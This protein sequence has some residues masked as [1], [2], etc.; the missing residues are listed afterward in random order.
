MNSLYTFVLSALLLSG[1]ATT[2][3]TVEEGW[4]PLD[5]WNH[6]IVHAPTP[7]QDATVAEYFKN[8]GPRPALPRVYTSCYSFRRYTRCSSY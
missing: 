3:P 5:E 4:I 1:C 7:R 8:A 6:R 2:V